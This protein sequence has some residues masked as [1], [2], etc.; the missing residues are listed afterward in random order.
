MLV[1]DKL[2]V[3]DLWDHATEEEIEEKIKHLLFPGSRTISIS[4]F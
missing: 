4:N 3:D 2:S 1:S